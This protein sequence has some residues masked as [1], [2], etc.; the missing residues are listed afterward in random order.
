[1]TPYQEKLKDSR[2]KTLRREVVAHAG[3]KCEQCGDNRR[4]QVH[5]EYYLRGREPWEYDP[6]LLTCLCDRC[7]RERQGRLEAVHIGL[8]QVLRYLPTERLERVAW[9]YLC[10][11]MKEAAL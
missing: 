6:S 4:L 5:H 2:W 9:L 10:E 11:G 1:M 7:H 8:A 3:G